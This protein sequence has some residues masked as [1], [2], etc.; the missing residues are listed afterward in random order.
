M[1]TLNKAA[2]SM[3]TGLPAPSACKLPDAIHDLS[4]HALTL[5]VTEGESV[6]WQG[7]PLDII[8]EVMHVSDPREIVRLASTCKSLCGHFRG[9]VEASALLEEFNR[10]VCPMFRW[11]IVQRGPQEYAFRLDDRGT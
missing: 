1:S 7:T 9:I 4:I 10:T 5:Q 6:A 11:S 8:Q 2:E 3:K